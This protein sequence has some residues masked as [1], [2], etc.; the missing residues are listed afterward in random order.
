MMAGVPPTV[1]STGTLMPVVPGAL[2]AICPLNCPEPDSA[3]G[4]TVTWKEPGRFPEAGK[5][6]SQFPPLLVIAA[7][8]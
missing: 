1:T 3:D 7:A 4:F 8:V 6:V 5:T 2:I